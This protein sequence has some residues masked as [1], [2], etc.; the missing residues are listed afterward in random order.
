MDIPPT[1]KKTTLKTAATSVKVR[2][3]L[4]FSDSLNPVKKTFPS[5][6][7]ISAWVS[8]ALTK[9][10]NRPL[11][12]AELSIRVVDEMESAEFNQHYRQKKSATNV[13]SFPA[14]L[15]ECVESALLGDLL[16]CAPVLEQEAIQ[17]NK[18]LDAH[19]AH[20][21]IHGTLHLLGYDHIKVSDANIMENLEINILNTLNFPNPY[22]EQP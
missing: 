9:Q 6:K 15:P 2:I 1:P 10:K 14:E 5:K 7:Q 18:T 4:Q 8:S 17:Q 22:Q 20:I 19:W 3:D 21:I 16:I 11:A 13:L 12:H